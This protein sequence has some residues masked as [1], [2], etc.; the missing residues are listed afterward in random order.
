MLWR[1]PWVLECHWDCDVA[2]I[3]SIKQGVLT[4]G[5]GHLYW[6]GVWARA[7]W[8]QCWGSG[9]RLARAGV[10]LVSNIP[11][12]PLSLIICALYL[13]NSVIPI[14]GVIAPPRIRLISRPDN[15]VPEYPQTQLQYLEA[16][17]L[18][19]PGRRDDA[20]GH[21]LIFI[22]TVTQRS[23]QSGPHLYLISE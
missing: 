3:P 21:S 18:V 13:G 20:W 19:W 12:P 4:N 7:E 5:P 2:I 22:K 1:K 17:C 6:G 9:P 14:E 8:L 11:A 16:T 10:A 15:L 23:L